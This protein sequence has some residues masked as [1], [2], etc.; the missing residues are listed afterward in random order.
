MLQIIR[1]H[2]DSGLPYFEMSRQQNATSGKA[3][4]FWKSKASMIFRRRENSI[5]KGMFGHARA[6]HMHGLHCHA[7]AAHECF[8]FWFLWH[9]YSWKITSKLCFSHS[10]KPGMLHDLNR[11]LDDKLG[12]S[13]RGLIDCPGFIGVFFFQQKIMFLNFFF[14]EKT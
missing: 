13:T 2:E 11:G 12:E 9:F 6:W 5:K 1:P 4:L 8:L 7:C 3:Y 10:Y 14:V